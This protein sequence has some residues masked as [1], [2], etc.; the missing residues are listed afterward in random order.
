MEGGSAG[1][2][3]KTLIGFTAQ[4]APGK[5]TLDEGK[6][7][8]SSGEPFAYHLKMGRYAD[9]YNRLFGK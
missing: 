7:F 5:V 9:L 1:G 6:G 8:I 2:K 3:R 4:P